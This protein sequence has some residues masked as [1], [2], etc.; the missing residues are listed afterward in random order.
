M[1]SSR[2]SDSMMVQILQD[3]GNPPSH[4][5]GL[6]AREQIGL[7]EGVDERDFEGIIGDSP[8]LRTLLKELRIVAPTDSAVLIL[9]ETGTGKELVARAIHNLGLRRDRPFVK[10]NCAAIPS[11][12]LESE[13]FGHE[14]G[15]FTGAIQ[16]RI[17]R[18]ELAHGGTLFLDEIGDIPL[19]LQP[20]LLRALQEQEF[21]RLGSAQTIRVDVRVVAAT[22]RDLPQM[23]AAAKFRSDLYYRINVFPLRMP[24]LRERQEDIAV[25]TRHFIR[26]SSKRLNK[27][28][29]KIPMGAM[30]AL[31]SYP[32]PGNVRQLQNFIERAVILSPGKVLR[33]PLEELIQAPERTQQ[34]PDR[35]EL[36]GQ[37]SLPKTM[38]LMETERDLIM[39]ILRETNW[40]VGGPRGA[41]RRLG[42]P[43]TTLVSMMQRL[44]IF[45]A[46]A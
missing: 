3:T 26:V 10:V 4:E 45:R 18:F 43:R 6:D 16:R 13:L 11:G 35:M 37:G 24:A 29:E 22:S 1:K 19:E 41:A 7:Q 33:P 20:K 25:L 40:I 5:G 14:R 34:I 23:V 46:V 12:L 38:T 32:W 21:E 31:A 8:Q 39:K 42:L 27:V 9:G 2:F 17:G 28:I 44:G 36:P 30:E 15:A